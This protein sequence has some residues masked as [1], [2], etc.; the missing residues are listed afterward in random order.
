MKAFRSPS[1]R[2]GFGVALAA[3]LVAGLAGGRLYAGELTPGQFPTI[4]IKIEDGPAAP[5][6]SHTP[7]ANQYRP[8]TDASGGYALTSPSEHEIL[9]NRAHVR[10]AGL[11]FDPDPFVLNNI[12]VTNTT[13]APQVFSAFVGL[14]TSFPAPNL[15]SGVIQTSVIDGGFDGATLAT[16]GGTPIYQ[17]QID[18]AT[19]GTLQ[20]DPFSLTALPAGT[21]SASASFGPIGSS[22]P[23]NTNIGIQLRFSLTPGDTAAILSRFDVVV[24]EPSSAVMIGIGL[25]ALM[26]RPR[27]R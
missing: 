9:N 16:A 4:T 12:L 17:A 27:R 22:V 3:W 25:A 8:A 26:A 24:P 15:I 19:V 11:Q 21:N 10:I 20:S 14:P 5:G 13:N 23:V 6:W 1:S 7:S 2:I 18:F